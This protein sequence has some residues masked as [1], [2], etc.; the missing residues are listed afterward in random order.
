MDQNNSSCTGCW[1]PGSVGEVSRKCRQGTPKYNQLPSYIESVPSHITQ[2]VLQFLNSKHAV[3]IPNDSVRQALWTAY[4]KLW[5]KNQF[6]TLPMCHARWS[7]VPHCIRG[8]T[9]P[10]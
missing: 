1:S 9:L 7:G 10:V 2:D 4:W 3:L 5:R 8:S 6:V